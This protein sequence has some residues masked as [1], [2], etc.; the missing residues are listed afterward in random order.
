MRAKKHCLSTVRNFGPT[1][2]PLTSAVKN[3]QTDEC[4]S[5]K[6][7]RPA[8]SLAWCKASYGGGGRFPLITNIIAFRTNRH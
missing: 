1:S 4:H 8:K 6:N 5:L 2:T 7:S 3:D